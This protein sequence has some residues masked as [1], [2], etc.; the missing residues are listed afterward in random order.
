MALRTIGKSRGF[1]PYPFLFGGI[2]MMR[3]PFSLVASSVVITALAF[4]AGCGGES[5]PTSSSGSTGTTGSGTG[6]TTGVTG[7]G[8][9]GSGTGSTG[10][11]GATGA[12]TT[13]STGSNTGATGSG[14]GTTGA[15]G[16]S[17]TSG[18]G[19]TLTLPD[20]GPLTCGACQNATA[21]CNTL[22]ALE[23]LEAGSCDGLTTSE[24]L[25]QSATDQQGTA[26]GCAIIVA[27]GQE[28]AISSCQ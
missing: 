6:S 15:T 5:G 7:I 24:C 11:T 18:T 21:C 23:G 22:A 13:G 16:T 26:E 25:A 19:I 10:A 8:A 14:T 12:G 4:V 9:T 17:G 1:L 2:R 20:G 3:T 27:L 28:L